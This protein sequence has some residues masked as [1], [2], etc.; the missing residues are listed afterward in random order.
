MLGLFLAPRFLI[1]IMVVNMPSSAF[2]YCTVSV[3]PWRK[4]LRGLCWA[5]AAPEVI[6]NSR[7]Y[8]GKKADVWSAGVMLYVILFC[9]AH[10]VTICFRL[11]GGWRTSLPIH[12]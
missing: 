1:V 8:D 4:C 12:A 2:S 3:A 7:T 9:G 11:H 5:C 10:L 6:S